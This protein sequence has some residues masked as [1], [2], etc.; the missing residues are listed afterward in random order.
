[1]ADKNTLTIELSIK[2]VKEKELRADFEKFMEQEKIDE[3][4]TNLGE[5]FEDKFK[6]KK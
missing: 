4:G 5:L 6:K 3:S 2:R 1:V